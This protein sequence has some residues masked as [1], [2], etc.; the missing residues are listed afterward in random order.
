MF[1]NLAALL[2]ASRDFGHRAHLKTTSLSQHLALGSFYEDLTNLLDELIEMYQG[3]NSVVE[4]PY[5]DPLQDTD[6]I[7]VL[8]KHL[9]I[10]ENVRSDA[11][12]VTDTPLQNKVDEICGVYLR[13]L[14]KLKNLR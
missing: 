12:P 1:A 11:I 9:E 10:I 5:C 14:Y 8:T 7:V 2:F 6:P 13:T 4:I 3:R